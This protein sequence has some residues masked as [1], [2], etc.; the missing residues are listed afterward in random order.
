MNLHEN[1]FSSPQ[2]IKTRKAELICRDDLN[3]NDCLNAPATDHLGRK[4]KRPFIDTLIHQ[5]LKEPHSL[6]E[7]DVREEVDT[8]MFEG[9]DTTAWGLTWA[10]YLL[11]LHEDVQSKCHDE[12]DHIFSDDQS[13]DITMDDL[14]QMKYIECV[15]K[16]SQRLYP[17][18]PI[19]GRT[20]ST[21]INV[22]GHLVPKGVSVLI[23]PYLVHRDP[24]HWPQPERFI[25]ERFEDAETLRHRHPFAF[26]PFSAG[27]R[28]CIGQRFALLEEKAIIAS[29]LRNYRIRSRETR[30]K[31]RLMPAL[32]LKSRLPIQVE[33]VRR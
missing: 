27:P 18:V 30:D 26:I 33:L 29:L 8:F 4:R 14:R 22:T 15:V 31:V 10:V 16:E 9:H 5:H 6:S 3:A 11:G 17:S 23:L 12:L 28:N 2:V 7:L 24:K 21:D 13:R 1:R 25:P 19:L 32:I 20:L